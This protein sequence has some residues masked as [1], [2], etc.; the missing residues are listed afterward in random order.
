M[1]DGW[2]ETT[3]DDLV[4]SGVVLLGRGNVISKKDMEVDP[5]PYPVYSSA[6]NNDGRIGLYNKFM[7][8]EELIT[9]SVDGGGHIFY[10]PHHKFSV[11]NIGGYLRILD[12]SK[13]L[14][15]F[16]AAVLQKLHGQ[17]VFDWQNKAHPSVIRK[18]Y[19]NIPLASINEQKRIVDVVSSVDSYIDALQKQAESART[20][21]L[22][23]CEDIFSAEENLKPLHEVATVIMGQS[24]EGNTCNTDGI[25]TPLL[26]GP[27][28][29]TK[30]TVGPPRQWT[31]R[32]TKLSRSGDILFCVRGATAGRIN[33][34]NYQSVIGRGLAAI[35]CKTHEDTDLV[36]YALTVGLRQL[37]PAAGGTIFP[38]ISRAQLRNFEVSWPSEIRRVELSAL[39]KSIEGVFLRAE[40]AVV[41]AKKLRSGL[42]SD[43]L[44]GEHEI[45]MSYDKFLKAA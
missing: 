20:A 24:P 45:P 5:G 2:T 7:F 40:Q 26:N 23:V 10:R 1:R 39:L 29:F 36:R 4:L 35:R 13:F 38:N 6:Q 34:G 21:F 37:L 31:S 32:E 11:T 14:Y 44:S 33:I 27:T 22:A 3:L 43:L 25:G 8:D 41:K 9:W 16:L 12:N 30:I 17:H 19:N 42:L 28:E 18:L 15:P